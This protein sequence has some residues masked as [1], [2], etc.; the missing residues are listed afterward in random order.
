MHP[1]YNKTPEF[2]I[3]KLKKKTLISNGYKNFEKTTI[4]KKEGIYKEI[5]IIRK[6]INKLTENTFVMICKNII[7]NLDEIKNKYDAKDLKFLGET[8]FKILSN[9]SLFSDIYALLY[10]K[11]K[12]YDFMEVDI[13]NKIDK[14]LD[15][16]IKTEDIKTE[17]IKTEDIKTEDIKTKI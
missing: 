16:Y 11:L 14:F 10:L 6:Y 4:I 3:E 1:D 5:D 15:I 2:L 9:N 8:I 7:D 13:K 12:N 17:D